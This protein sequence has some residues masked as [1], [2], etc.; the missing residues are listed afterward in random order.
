MYHLDRDPAES[1]NRLAEESKLA[2]SI[3]EQTKKFN[4]SVVPGPQCPP[5]APPGS[6]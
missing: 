1:V 3:A 2:A 6:P 5:H 4:A